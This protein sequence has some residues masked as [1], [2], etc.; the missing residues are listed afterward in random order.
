LRIVATPARHAFAYPTYRLFWTARLTS[1]LA[2][3]CTI[4][5][6]GW[7]VYDLA[8]RAMG[9][10]AAS[11]QLGL[12]GL[13]QFLPLFSLVLVTGWTADRVDRA[14]V[15][16]LSTSLQLVGSILLCWASLVSQ[17]S[18]MPFFVVAV[19]LGIA[20]AFSSPA[21]SA[22]S[23]NLVP[24]DVLPSAIATNS[25][26][27]RVGQILGPAAGGYLYALT[28]AA[29]YAFSIALFVIS[30][31]CMMF[32]RPGNRVAIDRT[33]N[34]WR[35]MVE[36]LAFVRHNG[37]VLGAISLDLF[38]VLLGGA[39]ALLPAYARDVLH[40][41]PT[42]LGHLRAAPAIGAIGTALWFAWRPL[43]RR[44]GLK[45]LGAVAIFGA[46][47]V[48]FGVSR[49]I[50]LSLVSLV[51][52]GA[53]DMLSVYVR[54]SLIQLYT[55]N[56]M[57][58]RVGAVSTLFVSASNELGEAESGFLA[59][60]VGPVAAVIGGGIGAI[61]ITALWAKLFPSLRRA[62]NFDTRQRSN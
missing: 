45:M 2:Q 50:A 15:V 21:L 14:M 7:Q 54:Q 47:T 53:A 10:K 41:G 32:V 20:R 8:R 31:G 34:P 23:P 52:L 48:V 29:P 62:G 33:R 12:I 22:L 24:P 49:N 43:K 36:G 38:A 17:A 58:G 37:L 28:P 42:T 60:L 9:I 11:L 16:R 4:V 59:A 44:I 51:V 25:I 40:A 55:P 3:N 39:T 30:L 18:L 57:R 61:A 1:T 6:I 5:V 26:A 13:A 46:A 56:E 35:Q 27:G 19:M